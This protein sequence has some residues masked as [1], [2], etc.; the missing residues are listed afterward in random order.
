[1]PQGNIKT[2]W[3]ELLRKEGG[4]DGRTEGQRL[5]AE[6][7]ELLK[8]RGSSPGNTV[9]N[10]KVIYP[11]IYFLLILQYYVTCANKAIWDG[12][13]K[14]WSFNTLM[15]FNQWEALLLRGRLDSVSSFQFLCFVFFPS[16]TDECNQGTFQ[17]S[18]PGVLEVMFWTKV[19]FVPAPA[20]G[21]VSMPP[22]RL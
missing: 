18:C 20:A 21:V 7:A 10:K 9:R 22:L 11:L 12:R 14:G 13:R 5:G 16:Q 1:M 19:L 15:P 4:T 8:Q 3:C 6:G 17:T 2:C